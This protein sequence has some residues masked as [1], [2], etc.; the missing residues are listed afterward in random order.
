MHVSSTYQDF[1][2]FFLPTYLLTYV[3]TVK[4]EIKESMDDA[5][6]V[7]T[8]SLSLSLS[9]AQ[10]FYTQAVRMQGRKV[11]DQANVKSSLTPK[12]RIL[13]RRRLL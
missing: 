6:F 5:Q 8:L 7:L 9:P 4:T 13:C 2:V 12:R 3:T 1:G 10:R 11:I